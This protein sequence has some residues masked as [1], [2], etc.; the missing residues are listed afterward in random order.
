M[1]KTI[2]RFGTLGAICIAVIFFLSWIIARPE[3]GNYDQQEI[4]GYASIIL[5][6]LFVFLGIKYYRDKVNNGHISFLQGLKLGILIV[7]FP[8]L[9]FAAI[10]I[11]WVL[12]LDPNFAE[13][14]YAHEAEK[15]RASLSASE[16]QVKLKEMEA[17]KE[18]FSNP[19]IGFVVMFMTVFIIGL[20]VTVISALILKRSPAAARA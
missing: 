10:D 5:S 16:L 3:S 12:V 6:M 2:L 13:K 7:L 1:K 8:S 11:I 4:I 14:Y 9:A 19:A 20:I 15:L 17:Q 18:M